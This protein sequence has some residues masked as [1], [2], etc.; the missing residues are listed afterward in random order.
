[1]IGKIVSHYKIIER[2]GSG[3]MGVVYKAL[4]LDLDRLVVLKFLAKDLSIDIN[5]KKRFIREAKAASKL[6]HINICT[7]YE[8]G[9]IP[10]GQI[11]IS[12]AYYEGETLK[13][14]LKRGPLELERA[15]DFAIQISQGLDIA[16][17][18]GIIHRDLKPANLIVTREG[19]VKIIDFGLAKMAE[20]GDLTQ[21]RTSFGTTAY[22]SPQQICAE[23]LDTRTDIWSAGVILYEMLTGQVPFKGD[24]EPTIIYSILSEQPQ[25]VSLIKANL[26]P[27]LDQI[28]ST[29][30]A[31][32]PN[33]RY[34]TPGA[35]RNDLENLKAGKLEK[36]SINFPRKK[37]TR[38]Q[39]VY[40]Y[41]VVLGK[42]KKLR[43]L[44]AAAI[45][46]IILFSALIIHFNKPQVVMNTIVIEDVTVRGERTDQESDI[47]NMLKYLL[48][49]ALMQ[50]SYKNVF[51]RNEFDILNPDDESET[52]LK[53]T[54]NYLN[55][56]FDL[57][58]QIIR[59]WL[60]YFSRKEDLNFRIYDPGYLISEVVPEIST[61]LLKYQKKKS[62]F[63]TSWD[64]F[65]NLYKG[66]HTWRRL[67]VSKAKQYFENAI[68]IDPGFVLAKLRLAY[69]HSFEANYGQVRKLVD[70]I[71]PYT[72]L[73]SVTDSLRA[74][75]LIARTSNN[76]LKEI[77][78]LRAI[79]HRF[80]LRKENSYEVA[81]AYFLICDIPNAIKYYNKS[82]AIDTNF[83]LAHN[84]LAYCYSHKGEHEKALHHF[85]RYLALD[86]TANAY[87]SMSDG[88]MA[89]GLLDSAEIS[90][91]NGIAVDSTISFL[92]WTLFEIYCRQGRINEA[93]FTA[94][95]YIFHSYSNDA[96]A[97]GYFMKAYAEFLRYNY[98]LAYVN[99]E[100]ALKLYDAED[101]FSRN[102]EL[103]WLVARLYLCT[104][105][106]RN[107]SDELAEFKRIIKQNNINANNYRR[108][109]YKFYLH[110]KACSAAKKGN[111]SELLDTIKEF[112]GPIRYK[113]S[114]LV[115][116]FDLAYFNTCFAELL[117]QKPLE[118]YDLAAKRLEKALAYNPNF[119]LAYYQLY[120]LNKLRG[121][122]AE[123]TEHAKRFLYLWRNADRDLPQ[124]AQI[125][126]GMP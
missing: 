73:L 31:K 32:N 58:A 33:D 116:Q 105:Y 64:A 62:S 115:S 49:D 97:R 108:S 112:D 111:L 110:L 92:Y 90:I 1:M 7:I 12:M 114:D 25:P 30:I 39:L 70:E 44:A 121:E 84:H 55:I 104:N 103:H 2:L 109:V 28:I 87:D 63:T 72:G 14:I 78:I 65:T 9:E 57:N 76:N 29:A 34:A 99:C 83:S 24:Y 5:A 10:S 82:L 41:S 46:V 56:G 50:S 3:G 61:R 68:E 40:K 52:S 69:T 60:V 95:K 93:L 117:M 36:L 94:D 37:F 113:V 119:A 71:S 8:I 15:L 13:E 106:K 91:K 43:L 98:D 107:F 53:V 81:E 126:S 100:Q 48:T 123:S 27:E 45:I 19:I 79:Y 51:D 122:I 16:Y 21:S 120:Q 89:A 75:A 47:A 96:Q 23:R 118:R 4:D 17:H 54:I 101:V 88:F 67:E 11:F 20:E 125:L 35:L 42:F 26:P 102:H 80:P 85:H 59:P 6:D 86:G 18:F 74:E 66:E 124:I 77:E 22:M 38:F